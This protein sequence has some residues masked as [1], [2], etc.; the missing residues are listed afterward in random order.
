MDYKKICILVILF[1]FLVVSLKILAESFEF[2]ENRYNKDIQIVIARFK[3]D[4]D[5]LKD[6]T[7][8]DF[9][10]IIY[11][12][13]PPI[14]DPFVLNNYKIIDLEN[15][16]KIDHT[17]LYHIIQNYNHLHDTTV[18]IPAS[19]F[20]MDN[21]LHQ[22]NMIMNTLNNDKDSN[23]ALISYKMNQ[24]V[25]KELYDFKLDEWKSSS[26]SNWDPKVDNEMLPSP[27][28]PFGEWYKKMFG[29][30]QVD[31]IFMYGIFAVS[32]EQIRNN[33]IEKYKELI[34]FVDSHPNPE[35]GHYLERSWTTL[36]S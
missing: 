9:D 17:I 15:V 29:D 7:I 26:Q 6:D 27:I 33:P 3:E 34:S 32:K 14:T 31:E 24:P 10:V 5:F 8:H 35:V 1:S 20:H 2:Y 19:I 21:K 22:L 28:R 30:K 13:G 12:K 36:F 18:F 23:S 16:G 25:I 11:N 4:L